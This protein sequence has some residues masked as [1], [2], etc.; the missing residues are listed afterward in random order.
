MATRSY[1]Q[2]GGPVQ[3]GLKQRSQHLIRRP[4]M[5]RHLLVAPAL[6]LV[7]IVAAAC[8]GGNGSANGPTVTSTGGTT[9]ISTL[10][11]QGLAAQN[12]G[13]L[14]TAISDYNQILAVQP[15]NQYA[16]YD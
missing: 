9:Q 6:V 15:A 8:G 12:A 10:L 5:S 2:N 16:L 11:S 3:A 14:S 4:A 1:R 13:N 7:A